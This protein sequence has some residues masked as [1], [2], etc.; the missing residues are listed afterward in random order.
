MEQG[1][2]E[3]FVIEPNIKTLPKA[4]AEKGAK[5]VK[6]DAALENANTIV[7]LADHKKFKKIPAKILN[8]KVVIDTRGFGNYEIEIANR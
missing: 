7:A 1:I 8:T 2:G 6:L 4:L 5:L 3:V